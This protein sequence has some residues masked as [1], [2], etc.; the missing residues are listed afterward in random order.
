MCSAKLMIPGCFLAVLLFS[1]PAVAERYYSSG[2]YTIHYNALR[3]DILSQ[4]VARVY[5]IVR[6]TNRAFVNISVH[7]GDAGA[8]GDAVRAQVSATATNLNGQLRNFAVAGD[9]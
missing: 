9:S 1:A 5:G 8:D 7:K 6:S 3:T 2:G 4:D